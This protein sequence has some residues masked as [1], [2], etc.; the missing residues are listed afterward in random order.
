MKMSDTKKQRC[1]LHDVLYV[2]E[3]SFNLLSVLKIT[4]AGKT[5]KFFSSGCHILDEKQNVIATATKV[6]SLCNL[7]FDVRNEHA[8]AVTKTS[9]GNSK[10]KFGIVNMAILV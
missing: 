6:G 10:E 7:N 9:N 4:E 5:L 3:L 2:Q 1:K 8:H